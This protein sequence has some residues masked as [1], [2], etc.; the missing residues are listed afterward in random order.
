MLPVLRVNK[1]ADLKQNKTSCFVCITLRQW[2]ILFSILIFII[3]AIITTCTVLGTLHTKQL[4]HLLE[5]DIEEERDKHRWD[6]EKSISSNEARLQHSQ[7]IVLTFSKILSI[8]M[9]LAWLNLVLA[10][11]LIY[12]VTTMTSVYI[13]PWI[14][15]SGTTYLL[16][17]TTVIMAYFSLIPGL[18]ISYSVLLVCLAGSLIFIEMWYTIV[19]YYVSLGRARCSRYGSMSPTVIHAYGGYTHTIQPMSNDPNKPLV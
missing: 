9:W 17:I 2:A 7:D 15:I 8:C 16:A 10:A 13:I 11:I 1:P 3:M 12:G 14:L 5:D 18:Y 19:L 6:D 4:L